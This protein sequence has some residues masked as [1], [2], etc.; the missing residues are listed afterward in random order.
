MKFTIV[1]YFEESLKLSI[2]AEINQDATKLDGN[3]ELV[4]KMVKAKGKADI[5][6]NFYI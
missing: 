3:Q 6:L 1:R 4:S 5:Q 2:K